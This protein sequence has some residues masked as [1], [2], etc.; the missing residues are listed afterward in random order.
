[1]LLSLVRANRVCKFL[2]ASFDLRRCREVQSLLDVFVVYFMRNNLH[3][4]QRIIL[5]VKYT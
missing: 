1:M 5:F 4:T 3:N 2:N